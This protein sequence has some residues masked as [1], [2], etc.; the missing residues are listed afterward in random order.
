MEVVD[1]SKIIFWDHDN[2]MTNTELRILSNVI[3]IKAA[4]AI[5]KVTK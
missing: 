5:D 3:Y 1:L 2:R 4:D